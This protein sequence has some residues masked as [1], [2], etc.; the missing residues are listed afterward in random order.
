[1]ESKVKVTADKAGSIISVSKNN[2]EW[3]HI[4]VE[5]T[6]M[7]L[8]DKGFARATRL[9]ALIPG[10]VEHLS[11]FGFTE[12]QELSGRIYV[13]EQTTPFNEKAPEKDVKVAGTTGV[14]CKFG[15]APIFRKNFYSEDSA[16]VDETLEHTNTEEIAAA[17]EAMKSTASAMAP[18]TDFNV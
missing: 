1:M 5:Q 3:G 9:S 6:R 11:A 13:K 12:G 14:I 2:P 10:T 4:R 18:S 17:R 16:K 8:D 7:Q 15:E